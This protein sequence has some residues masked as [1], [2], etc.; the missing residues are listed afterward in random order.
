MKNMK[1]VL[2]LVLAL[3]MVFSIVLPASA[4][5]TTEAVEF[6]EIDNDTVKPDLSDR[7]SLIHI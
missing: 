4:A 3:V 1:K 7:L 2:S 5:N 6:V